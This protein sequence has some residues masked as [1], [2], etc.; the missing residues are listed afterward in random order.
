MTVETPCIGV[1]EL[2]DNG[3]CFGCYRSVDQIQ[4][5]PHLDDDE[6]QII[7]QQLEDIANES[8][9]SISGIHPHVTLRTVE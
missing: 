9:E 7:I 2:D 4:T 3:F 5:W 1:C 8:T 6:K